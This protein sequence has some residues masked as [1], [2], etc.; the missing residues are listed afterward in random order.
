M[1]HDDRV[2]FSRDG[3]R[4]DTS[5]GPQKAADLLRCSASVG[6]CHNSPRRQG[7]ALPSKHKVGDH[8]AS[9]LVR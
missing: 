9:L 4:P 6:D 8:N 5:V 2:K 3:R 1:L 7:F